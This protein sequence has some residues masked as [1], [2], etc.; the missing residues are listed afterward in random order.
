MLKGKIS[1]ETR[2]ESDIEQSV[3]KLLQ[4]LREVVR[5]GEEL[6]K[7]GAEDLSERGAQAR[8][9][10]AAALEVARETQ[11]RIQERAIAGAK[12][13]DQLIRKN[14]YQAVGIAFGV[15]LVFGTILVGRSKR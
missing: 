5:D 4:D 1:M 14:P 12:A 6:L 15:G 9:K 10:L 11:Q 13:A 8:E 2:T 7:A 3:D